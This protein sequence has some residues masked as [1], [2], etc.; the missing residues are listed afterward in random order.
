MAEQ[1][2]QLKCQVMGCN[3]PAEF[4]VIWKGD[5]EKG[6][7][8]LCESCYHIIL[9]GDMVEVESLNGRPVK[10]CDAVLS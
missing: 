3:T 5:R 8:P 2:K 1:T 4:S 6:G 10:P 9:T 7:C